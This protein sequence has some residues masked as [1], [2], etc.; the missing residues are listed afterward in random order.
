MIRIKNYLRSLFFAIRPFEN[1]QHFAM[2]IAG[3]TYAAYYYDTMEIN[4]R[5]VLGFIAIF[6]FL[7]QV[8]SYNNYATFEKDLLDKEKHFDEK[9]KGIDIKFLLYISIFFFLLTSIILIFINV[10]FCVVFMFL[11]I[12]WA[13]YTHPIIMLKKGR[14]VPYIL[15]M[16]TMPVL[17]IF[18]A[19]LIEN[20]N[21]QIILFSLF[22]GFIEIAGHIN[23]ITMD[24]D[25]DKKTG[26]KT[27]AVRIGPKFTFIISIMFFI[28]ASVYFLIISLYGVFPKIIGFIYFPGTII[29]I[30]ISYKILKH[31]FDYN[32]ARSFRKLYRSIY[33]FESI[34]LEVF[35]IINISQFHF[36]NL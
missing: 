16:M 31:S 35:M 36:F 7:S 3:F 15:D 14:F 23:H 18:G 30:F 6:S 1:A 9:F 4:T 19:Y 5:V 29:Q 21:I 33:F 11:M 27:L 20:I 34:M 22:F 26:I 13:L 2:T 28:I 32:V 10:Y 12:A 24:Y 8:L 25:V 17:F